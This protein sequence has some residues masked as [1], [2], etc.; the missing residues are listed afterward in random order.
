MFIKKTN[1]PC[2]APLRI[3][4]TVS[5]IL[6]SNKTQ[7]KTVKFDDKDNYVTLTRYITN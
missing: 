4:V 2:E 1:Y 3:Y 7:T 5:I 6:T